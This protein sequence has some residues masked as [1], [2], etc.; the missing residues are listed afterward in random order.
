MKPE[1][2]EKLQTLWNYLYIND[3]VEKVDCI[4]GL[5]SI[6]VS[7]AQKCADLYKKGYGDYIIFSGNCGKGTEG[8][9]NKTEAELFAKIAIDEG[10]PKEKIYLEKEATNTYENFRNSKKIIKENHLKCDSIITVSKPYATRRVFA[11]SQIE[12][13]EKKV[14]ISSSEKS[15][16][17]FFSFCK[18]LGN[19]PENDMI[20]EVVGEISILQKAPKYKLQIEQKIPNKVIEAFIY[21]REAGFNKYMITEEQIKDAMKKLEKNKGEKYETR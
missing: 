10:V 3:K 11:I 4:F 9:I 6:D 7:V 16:E 1:V 19:A 5:G 21:L 20:S 18:Q 8:V 12:M 14:I 17:K 2:T 15:M 13:P